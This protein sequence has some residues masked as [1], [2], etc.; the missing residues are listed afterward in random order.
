M[1]QAPEFFDKK[2]DQKNIDG[3]KADLW[4]LGVTLYYILSGR[5]PYEEA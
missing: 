3:V 4:A 5:L 1:F 2:T